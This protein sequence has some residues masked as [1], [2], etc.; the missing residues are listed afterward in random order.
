MTRLVA[1]GLET[2]LS[3]LKRKLNARLNRK[4]TLSARHQFTILSLQHIF[5]FVLRRY[6][7]NKLEVYTCNIIALKLSVSTRYTQAVMA[8]DNKKLSKMLERTGQT[9]S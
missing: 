3:C 9:N 7:F 4:Q 8:F 6:K 2:E 5:L 1:E